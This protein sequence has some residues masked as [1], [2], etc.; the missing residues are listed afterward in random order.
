L[1]VLLSGTTKICVDEGFAIE[2]SRN[3]SH[4]GSEY[5][6][7]L[8]FGSPSYAVIVHLFSSSRIKICTKKVKQEISKK[9]NQQVG[10]K[11]DRVYIRVACNSLDKLLVSHDFGDIPQTVRDRLNK[12]I[13]VTIVEAKQALDRIQ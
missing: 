13:R 2:E 8:R 1:K 7:H 3:R 5:I 10:S 12:Q 4:I 9:I 11:P 6:K